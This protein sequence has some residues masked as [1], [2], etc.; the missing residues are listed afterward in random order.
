MQLVQQY[1]A[2]ALNKA[3]FGTSDGGLLA[4]AR[5]DCTAGNSGAILTDVGLLSNLNGS[6]DPTPFPS[7]F[8]NTA[9]NSTAAQNA[10]NKI[11]W[12]TP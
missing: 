3:A 8:I 6:G 9:A 10:A 2:A 11:S 4:Q 5:A 12:N 7:S 1:L